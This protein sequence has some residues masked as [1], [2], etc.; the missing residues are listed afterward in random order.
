M[1]TVT[2]Y[3]C[4]IC[5]EK[6]RT[7]KGALECEAQGSPAAPA[8]QVGDIVTCGAGFGWFDGD[9]KWITNPALI[10]AYKHGK[11]WP[12][13]NGD[14]NCF[15]PCCTLQFYYVVTAVEGEGG[16]EGHRVRYHVCT[17]AMKESY[18]GGYTYDKHHITPVKVADPPEYVVRTSK[19]VLGQ[20]FGNLL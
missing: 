16:H 20:K 5:G 4:E 13:P 9:P 12:C 2:Q 10:E 8:F 19:S 14:G 11:P 17:L 3:V 18:R 7:E 6:Y 15:S 1:K